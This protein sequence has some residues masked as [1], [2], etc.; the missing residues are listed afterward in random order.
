[1]FHVVNGVQSHNKIVTILLPIGS[2]KA[3]FMDC[4]KSLLLLLEVGGTEHLIS[5]VLN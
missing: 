4:T 5:P 2:F 3:L 1:M